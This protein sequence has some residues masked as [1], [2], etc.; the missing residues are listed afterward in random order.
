[1]IRD[2]QSLLMGL[3]D[4]N[5]AVE[6]SALHASRYQQQRGAAGVCLVFAAAA[7]VARPPLSE[8]RRAVTAVRQRHLA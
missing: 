8:H 2:K 6:S 7:E 4:V 3:S 5:D 1:M